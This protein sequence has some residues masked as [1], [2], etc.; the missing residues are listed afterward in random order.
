M[1]IEYFLPP[2][3]GNYT[4]D[5]YEDNAGEWRWRVTERNGHIV[6]VPG[7]GYKNKSHAEDMA[8]RLFWYLA[9]RTPSTVT[10][11]GGMI[12]VPAGK[13]YWRLAPHTSPD[14]AMGMGGEVKA[15]NTVE[16]EIRDALKLLD[17][18]TA[19]EG[20]ED[21]MGQAE[22]ALQRALEALLDRP[23]EDE[24]NDA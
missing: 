20:S 24:Q 7:E 3:M 1:P 6:A 11:A 8:G 17:N 12:Q 19:A 10:S 23:Y 21:S 5:V 13:L 9:P 14:V 2:N 4:V 16:Q 18:V 22:L 15:T